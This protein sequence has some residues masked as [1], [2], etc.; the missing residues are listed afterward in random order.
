MGVGRRPWVDM[1]FRKWRIVVISL[2]FSMLACLHNSLDPAHI[3]PLPSIMTDSLLAP[4]PWFVYTSAIAWLVAGVIATILPLDAMAYKPD[5]FVTVSSVSPETTRLVPQGPTAALHAKIHAPQTVDHMTVRRIPSLCTSTEWLYY[6]A[7]FFIFWS[8]IF[9]IVSALAT[10]IFDDTVREADDL[11]LIGG[12]SIAI[13]VLVGMALAAAAVPPESEDN[14]C[15]AS[16][17]QMC[18][19]VPYPALVA[20]VVTTIS[21]LSGVDRTPDG[22]IHMPTMAIVFT[23]AAWGGISLLCAIFTSIVNPLMTGFSI[24]VSSVILYSGWEAILL[25]PKRDSYLIPF[26]SILGACSFYALL[27]GVLHRYT[28]GVLWMF[29]CV[30]LT[31]AFVYL[32]A[33]TEVSTTQIPAYVALVGITGV[34][35]ISLYAYRWISFADV[36]YN[37]VQDRYPDQRP[38]GWWGR[39]LYDLAHALAQGT[40]PNA[41]PRPTGNPAVL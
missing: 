21:I 38:T 31:G 1:F 24:G 36:L 26:V 6:I 19:R 11:S 14:R 10:V 34:V 33:R 22:Y 39:G 25:L 32:F 5:T 3:P 15:C 2:G 23:I 20:G 8:I 35:S 18:F 40:I 13:S 9:A 29:A 28:R 7:R 12:T 27:Y 37:Y 41:P 4:T 30:A 16:K 17:R